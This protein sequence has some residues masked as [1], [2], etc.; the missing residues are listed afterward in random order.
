MDVHDIID[1]E[2]LD[3]LCLGEVWNFTSNDDC[4]HAVASPGSSFVE[5]VR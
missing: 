4:L 2:Q 5:T 1:Q 3:V